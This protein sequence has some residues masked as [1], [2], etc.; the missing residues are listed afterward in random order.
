MKYPSFARE[1]QDLFILSVLGSKTKG[2]Y[3]EIGAY[4]PVEDNNT[5][6][7]E[8]QFEW[9]G[10]SLEFYEEYSSRWKAVRNNPCI[11]CDATT[12]NYTE[13]FEENNLPNHIDFLQIDIDPTSANYKVL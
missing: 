5:Y 2:T 10:I 7:L 9:K 11:T 12:V 4:M 8:N 3:V 13:L 6:L 1:N